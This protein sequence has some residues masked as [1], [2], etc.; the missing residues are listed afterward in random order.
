MTCLA[1]MPIREYGAL[2][3][4]TV[5]LQWDKQTAIPPIIP[6][7]SHGSSTC[8]QETNPLLA[9][10]VIPF[11]SQ[12]ENGNTSA[13][14]QK[15]AHNNWINMMLS[16]CMNMIIL[17][18]TSWEKKTKTCDSQYSCELRKHGGAKGSYFTCC[19]GR[20]TIRRSP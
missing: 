19:K 5:L 9:R 1:Q 7:L 11:S 17:H 10:T 4:S 14:P 12:T 20:H 2:Q 18:T 15:L 16:Q 3:P 6:I 13:D 8:T